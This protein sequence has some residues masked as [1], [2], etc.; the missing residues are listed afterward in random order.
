MVAWPKA[1]RGPRPMTA[2]SRGAHSESPEERLLAKETVGFY[3]KNGNTLPKYL[4][5]RCC[6]LSGKKKQ[7]TQNFK[8]ILAFRTEDFAKKN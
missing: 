1:Y 5:P 7:E 4:I 2:L 3:L 8:T 6:F